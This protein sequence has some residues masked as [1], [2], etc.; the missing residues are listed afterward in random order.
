[1][2][3]ATISRT[4]GRFVGAS[5]KRSSGWQ[6]TVA[7]KIV[8]GGTT[9]AEASARLRDGSVSSE[10][11]TEAALARIA[12]TDETWHWWGKLNPQTEGAVVV[13]R[14]SGGSD[15]QAINI[16]WVDPQKTYTIKLCFKGVLIKPMSG[17]DLQAGK[18]KLTLPAYGQEIIELKI[19]N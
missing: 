10:A 15:Q 4:F 13:L 2:S 14:G 6:H 1:M 18:L 9:L 17:K 16:P 5:A 8:H 19:K 11:L 12:A 7:A 3:S